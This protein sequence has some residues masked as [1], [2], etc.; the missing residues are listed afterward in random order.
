MI[1]NF[2]RSINLIIYLS[3]Y[4]V[5]NNTSLWTSITG[6]E[7]L[8][9]LPLVIFFFIQFIKA[10]N[11]KLLRYVSISG[12]FV[13]LIISLINVY[14][15]VVNNTLQQ[16]LPFRYLSKYFTFYEGID[17][18][19]IVYDSTTIFLTITAFITFICN[20]TALTKSYHKY[21]LMVSLFFILEFLAFHFFITGNLLFVYI[22]FEA[23][24]I[25]TFILIGL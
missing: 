6:F 9:F 2:E 18:L 10:Y 24:V 19:V 4:F 22:Y 15:L 23:T 20:V 17:Y 21:K 8:V 3:K 14:T 11:L 25:P 7:I 16:E 1:E 12:S 5:V 13:V